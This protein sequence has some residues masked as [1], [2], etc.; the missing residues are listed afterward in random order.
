MPKI[1]HDIVAD[2]ASPMQ[3]LSHSHTVLDLTVGED[4]IGLPRSEHINR[5]L[6]GR[7]EA[8][9]GENI[10]MEKTALRNDSIPIHYQTVGDSPS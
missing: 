2:L 10:A 5:A 7:V 8:K 1:A 6:A 9:R 3:T 4:W